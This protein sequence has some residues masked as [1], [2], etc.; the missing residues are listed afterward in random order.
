MNICFCP[1]APFALHLNSYKE[2][3]ISQCLQSKGVTSHSNPF[4]QTFPLPQPY[5]LTKFWREDITKARPKSFYKFSKWEVK[6]CFSYDPRILVAKTT[7]HM[8]DKNKAYIIDRD[9]YQEPEMKQWREALDLDN[10]K[11]HISAFLQ[12]HYRN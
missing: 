9:R 8:K 4:S 2:L 5:I 10:P 3:L 11:L 7:H 1:T 6:T 12:F